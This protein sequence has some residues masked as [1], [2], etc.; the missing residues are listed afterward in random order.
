MPKFLGILVATGLTAF[1]PAGESAPL[2]QD[3]APKLVR[4]Y[5]RSLAP[6]RAILRAGRVESVVA[7]VR[8]GDGPDD[9]ITATLHPPDGVEI[10][11]EATREVGLLERDQLVRLEWEVRAATST[12][13][14]VL[15]T[16]ESDAEGFFDHRHFEAVFHPPS[17][18]PESDYVPE[19]VPAKT[20]TMVLAHHCPLWK[21]GAHVHGWDTIA[22]WPER[23]PAIGFYDEGTPLATDWHIKYALEHGIGGFIYVWDKTMMDPLDRNS[24]ASAIDDGFLQARYRD[25]FQFCLNWN[26]NYPGHNGVR[27][28]QEVLEEILPFWLDEYFS[29]ESYAK[30]DGRPLLFVNQP[31]ALCEQLGGAEA[32]RTVFDEMRARVVAAGHPGLIL[33][34][35]VPC[36][37]P[38]VQQR[39]AVAG[40]DA[41]SA[42]D[43]WVDGWAGAT[44]DHH[45]V[46]AFSHRDMMLAQRGVLE[47]K[48]LASTIPDVISVHMGWDSR[49]WHGDDATY[50]MAEPTAA[51][52]EVA[53]RSA[54]DLLRRT[55]GDGIDTRLVVLNNWN[56]FGEGHYIAPTTG[57]GFAF[58]DA[59]RRVFTDATEPCRHTIP[60]DVG[61]TPPDSIYQ[62]SREILRKP[63]GDRR[64]ATSD[65]AAWWSFDRDSGHV[66]RDVSG[67]GFDGFR[68]VEATEAG[69]AGTALSCPE[70]APITLATHAAFYPSSGF[71]VELWC[72]PRAIQASAFL[73]NAASE[74]HTGYGL[75]LENGKP[76][77][78]LNWSHR[79]Q[80]GEALP[81]GEWTHL[82]A[83]SDNQTLSLFVDGVEVARQAGV[84]TAPPTR[85]NLAVG[86]YSATGN[87]V[88]VGAIDEVKIHRRPLRAEELRGARRASV[89]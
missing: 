89:R 23:K 7:V 73:L 83:V 4:T 44:S 51:A 80:G 9:A 75:A 42:Y 11:G 17:T 50:Y 64:R 38:D 25:R 5:V 41:S 31:D 14:T 10:L 19:P 6:G 18:A 46:P 68:P 79:V 76:T 84:P 66:A 45:G 62:Q 32:T 43:L 21:Y 27:D 15:V 72:K 52:F 69:I 35:C 86:S 81:T 20:E 16:L 49:P 12:H 60:E 47:A 70:G 40:Y 2:A 87:P 58:L 63:F 61:L 36:A 34:G 37:K 54:K 48:R 77:F 53:C 88:F 24:L 8:G 65:L 26:M 74:P 33:I 28:A 30:I 57:F 82:A 67:G 78:Y 85:G 3:P 56:E 59:V 71:T 55:T 22:P 13:S 1:A 29:R 39:M